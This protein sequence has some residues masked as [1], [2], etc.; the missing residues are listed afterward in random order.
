MISA[1]IG[2]KGDVKW[3]KDEEN[4]AG[5]RVILPEYLVCKK[6]SELGLNEQYDSMWV[7]GNSSATLYHDCAYFGAESYSYARTLVTSEKNVFPEI[8]IDISAD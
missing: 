5:D 1:N 8:C 7:S 4:T 2:L 3:I 6:I